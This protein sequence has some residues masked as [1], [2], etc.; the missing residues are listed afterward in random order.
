MKSNA[1]YAPGQFLAGSK[2]LSTLIPLAGEKNPEPVIPQETGN[3]PAIRKE[4]SRVRVVRVSPSQDRPRIVY[5][6]PPITVTKPAIAPAMMVSQDSTVA[7]EFVPFR[8]CVK[9]SRTCGEFEYYSMNG[10]SFEAEMRD[11]RNSRNGLPNGH[12]NGERKRESFDRRIRTIR[13][14]A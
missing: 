9:T 7:Q 1:F 13:G 2:S 12:H 4:K 6:R 3:R 10:H 5:Q 11:K 14:L 8:F